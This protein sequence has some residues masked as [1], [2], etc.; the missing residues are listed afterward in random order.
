MKGYVG[1]CASAVRPSIALR[2]FTGKNET[3]AYL[4][5]SLNNRCS[6]FGKS[7]PPSL[8]IIVIV[9]IVIVIKI[10][11][12]IIVIVIAIAIAITI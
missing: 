10:P 11:I 8:I 1:F 12:V 5:A 6:Y 2:R 3:F 7:P 4:S 9:V